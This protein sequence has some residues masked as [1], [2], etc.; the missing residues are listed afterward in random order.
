MRKTLPTPDLVV[1]LDT[2]TELL[3]KNI[4]KRGREI[5]KSLKQTYLRRLKKT[6]DK[7]YMVNGRI[8]TVVLSLTIK[9]YNASTLETCCKEILEILQKIKK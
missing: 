8:N 2:S 6:L 5:E 9:E 3:E 1:Y 7:Y 4:H